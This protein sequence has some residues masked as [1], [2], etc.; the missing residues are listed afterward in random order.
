MQPL[1]LGLTTKPNTMLTKYKNRYAGLQ[2][3]NNP[4]Q[5]YYLK[6]NS[7]HDVWI[8]SAIFGE[9]EDGRVDFS[10]K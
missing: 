4:L 8:V 6:T 1:Y 10:R 9:V 2:T 3:R 7:Q 5:G